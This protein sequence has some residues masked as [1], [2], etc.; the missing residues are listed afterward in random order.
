MADPNWRVGSPRPLG[1]GTFVMRAKP[2]G[3]HPSRA[4]ARRS[5][6][7]TP[8]QLDATAG[9]SALIG[10]YEPQHERIHVVHVSVDAKSESLGKERLQEK[11][12]HVRAISQR[13]LDNGSDIETRRR[14]PRGSTNDL[15]A[16]DKIGRTDQV[17]QVIPVPV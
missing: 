2:H 17:M 16:V 7:V 1:A 9:S 8:S 12:P 13:T 6:V 10:T 14:H 5:S 4:F 15:R 11:P 3:G